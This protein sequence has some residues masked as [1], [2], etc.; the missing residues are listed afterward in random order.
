MHDLPADL[1]EHRFV[2]RRDLHGR[3]QTRDRIHQLH[4]HGGLAAL[5]RGE[6]RRGLLGEAER[7]HGVGVAGVIDGA[8]RP[9]PEELRGGFED[10]GG[11][12]GREGG[13]H[14]GPESGEMG[15]RGGEDGGDGVVDGGE[16]RSADGLGLDAGRRDLGR[17][18][19]E[20][21]EEA[22][23]KRLEIRFLDGA[24]DEGLER[25]RVRERFVGG[26][27][28]TRD[29][30]ENAEIVAELLRERLALLDDLAL[31]VVETGVQS[32]ALHLRRGFRVLQ[33]LVVG[34]RGLGVLEL[35]EAGVA[36]RQRAE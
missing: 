31:R 23:E 19:G 20:N 18:N 3:Q 16:E 29:H 8:L 15:V 27:E 4:Q 36:L 22:G 33:H 13:Q 10:F 24:V 6:Q 7:V 5:Q 12:G 1:C 32:L 17:E 14:G 26:R 9:D 28:D 21:A 25:G 2:L 35:V 11:R 30:I 34:L